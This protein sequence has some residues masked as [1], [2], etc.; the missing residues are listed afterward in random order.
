VHNANFQANSFAPT[1]GA[2]GNTTGP[3]QTASAVTSISVD[4]A[5]V[6]GTNAN[7]PPYFA[8]AYIM[9]T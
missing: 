5:G 6:S 1:P 2:G 8:L 9:K 4:T 7:L 3:G